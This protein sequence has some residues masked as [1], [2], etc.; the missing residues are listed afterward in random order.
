MAVVE[1][2]YKDPYDLKIVEPAKFFIDD[3]TRNIQTE[4]RDCTLFETFIAAHLL[5][6]HKTANIERSAFCPDKYKITVDCLKDYD[7]LFQWL[8]DNTEVVK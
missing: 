7:D 4:D 5:K 1:L 6:L 2:R 3:K 8:R